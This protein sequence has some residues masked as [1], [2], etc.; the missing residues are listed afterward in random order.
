MEAMLAGVAASFAPVNLF[1]AALGALIGTIVGV[2]PGLGPVATI[3]LLLPVSFQMSP[4]GAMILLA[5]V[6]YGAQYGSSTTAI[7][8]N[9]PGEA[10]GAITALEGHRLSRA[11]KAPEALAVAALASLVAGLLS[12]LVLAIATPPLAALALGIGPADTAA[13]LMG[14]AVLAVL[15]GGAS[16]AKGLLMLG[17]GG[18]LGLIGT[19]GGDGQ[20]RF[21]MG[22]ADLRDGIDFTPLVVGLFG[23]SE[24]LALMARGRDVQPVHP[25]RWWPGWSAIRGWFAPSIRG[26]GIGSLVGLLPGATT[27]FAAFCAYAL[28]LRL[29]NVGREIPTLHGVAAPEAANNAAAQ[30]SF[31]MLFGLGLPANAATAVLIGAMMIHGLPPGP[32]LFTTHPSLFWTFIGSLIVANI[33][34][35]ALNLPLIGL[36]ARL[37]TIPPAVLAPAILVVSGLGVL[38]STG[39]PFDVLSLG[40]FGL[41]GYAARRAGFPLLPLLMGYVIAAPFED[42]LRRAITH[43]RGDWLALAAQPGVIGL[44]VAIGTAMIFIGWRLKRGR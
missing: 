27:L 2:L 36:W 24:I 23:F 41:F 13:L 26:A 6:Y 12:A 18:L 3:A 28:E 22:L 42:H 37:V 44:V 43:A 11:G 20:P 38:A 16:A 32:A 1:Y 14:G 5:G 17:V 35:V 34:L 7:L 31:V 8:I 10:S 39:K 29:K 25:T 21:T 40:V 15:V 9:V 4:A 30:S 33:V 19:A